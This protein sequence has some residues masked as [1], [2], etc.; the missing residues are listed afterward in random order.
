MLYEKLLFL[1]DEQVGSAK[2]EKKD[3]AMIKE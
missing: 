3:E 1:S 2:E